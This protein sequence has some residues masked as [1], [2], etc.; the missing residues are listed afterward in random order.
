MS[1]SSSLN[2]LFLSSGKR[3]S[4]SFK[5]SSSPGAQDILG[6]DFL[7]DEAVAVQVLTLLG[8]EKPL[9]KKTSKKN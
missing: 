4:P 1:K 2:V 9:K 3:I 7:S 6:K 5:G 8:S